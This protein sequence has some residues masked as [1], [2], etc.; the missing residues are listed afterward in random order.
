MCFGGGH[1]NNS[2]QA[3]NDAVAQANLKLAQQ[4]RQ[5][6]ID[7]QN[8]ISQGITNVNDAFSGFNDNYYGKKSQDYLGYY[9]PQVEHQYNQA[10]DDTLYQLARQGLVNSSAGSKV[11]GDLATDYGNQQQAIQS[12]ANNYA[13]QARSAVEQQRNALINQ[14]TATANPQA[15]ANSATNA[16]GSLQMIQPS[17]GYS[18]LSG[19]FNTFAGAAASGLQNYAYGNNGGLLGQVFKNGSSGSSSKVVS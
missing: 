3:S 14:V 11:Y 2:A 12:G 7:R 18:P 9:Q 16:V 6:E 19:L 5:D 10:K 1:S 13:Q 8:R 4:Q 15:A 17:G